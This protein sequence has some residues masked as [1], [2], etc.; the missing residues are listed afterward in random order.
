MAKRTAADIRRL[1]A[2]L[3][4]RDAF[5]LAVD[6][7]HVPSIGPTE[8]GRRWHMVCS[9]GYDSPTTR[10]TRGEAARQVMTHLRGAVADTQAN[11]V[12][13][14]NLPRKVVTAG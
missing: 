9:C 5:A 12:N 11:R 1:T 10:A 4:D 14:E 13:G 7:G 2:H 8:S 3:S 6:L